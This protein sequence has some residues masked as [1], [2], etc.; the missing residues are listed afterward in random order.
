M[1]LQDKRYPLPL[2]PNKVSQLMEWDTQAGNI[3]KDS[4]SSSCWENHMKT[5][6]HVCY[7]CIGG[8]LGP[9]QVCSLGATKSLGYLTLLV[10]L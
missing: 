2:R 1:S 5:K 3:V 4:P 6:L 7:I 9:A 8:G 10:F